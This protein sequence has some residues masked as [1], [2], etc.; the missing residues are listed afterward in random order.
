MPQPE[1]V[2]LHEL[3]GLRVREVLLELPILLERTRTALL[4]DQMAPQRVADLIVDDGDLDEALAGGGA[5]GRIEVAEAAQLVDGDV[6]GDADAV[7]VRL[8]ALADK[9]GDVVAGVKYG[10]EMRI[11]GLQLLG[12]FVVCLGLLL[13]LQ[14][15]LWRTRERR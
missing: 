8:P 2:I 10:V 12:L 4:L 1:L 9:L 13:L 7:P 6:A 14:H 11:D 15:G 5:R 3:L